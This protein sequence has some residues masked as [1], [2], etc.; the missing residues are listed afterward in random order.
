MG[1]V[2]FFKYSFLCNENLVTEEVERDLKLQ[3]P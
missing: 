1:F 2:M 3:L